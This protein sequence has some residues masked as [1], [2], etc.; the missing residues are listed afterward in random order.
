[1]EVKHNYGPFLIIVPMSTLHN[2][3]EFECDRWLPG[4]SKVVYD[5]DKDRRKYLRENFIK[6]GHFNIIMTTFEFAMRDKNVLRKIPWKYIIIDEAHRL[7]NPSCFTADTQIAMANGF[8]RPICS[9]AAGTRVLS[10]DAKL[11]GHKPVATSHLLYQGLKSCVELLFNDGRTVTCTLDHRFMQPDSSWIE[12]QHMQLHKSEIVAGVEYPTLL[13]EPASDGAWTLRLSEFL[14][15]DL[16]MQ[17][18]SEHALAFAGILGYL[19]AGSH[20]VDAPCGAVLLDHSLDVDWMLRDI[21]LLTDESA[22]TSSPLRVQLP[23]ALHRALLAVGLSASGLSSFPSFLLRPDCPLAVLQAFLGGLFGRAGQSPKISGQSFSGV[24]LSLPHFGSNLQKTQLTEQLQA[25]F[26]RVG[27]EDCAFNLSSD[28]TL[29]FAST[30]GFRYCCHKAMRLTAAVLFHRM[31]ERSSRLGAFDGVNGLDLSLDSAL[32]AFDVAKFFT[33]HHNA[34]PA[35]AKALPTCRVQ[36]IARRA[37]EGMLPTFDLTVPRTHNFLA[38]AL[39][40]HNCKLAQ[41]LAT[42]PKEARRVALTG[43]PLQNDLVE[44][45][46]LLNF[47]HPHIF[48]SSDSFEK[49]F[50][51]PFDRMPVGTQDKEREMTMNEEEKLLVIN[52]LHSILRPFMLR[53]EKKQ[54]ESD[55]ADKIEK[56]LRCEL[57][58]MQKAMYEAVLEGKVTMHN[59]IMQLRKIA[60]HPILFHPYL[61]A[62]ARSEPYTPDESLIKMCGKFG[63]LD[64][65]LHKLK[66]TGHRVLIFNQMTKVM[67]ILED[68][69]KLRSFTY[70]RL[71]G[72]TNAEDR[73]QS[74]LK[75]NAKD[76]PYFLFMLST[77]AGGLGLNLQSADTVILFDSDWSVRAMKRRWA[78]FCCWLACSCFARCVCSIF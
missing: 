45:W 63:L 51:T 52:R 65:I 37:V 25:M 8:S 61:R 16:D 55:L 40:A 34:V 31:Q 76:S 5:G 50:S 15:Y 64:Q 6:P 32:D 46:S 66:R 39:T 21:C 11:D 7:K 48:N 33:M 30:I 62:Q 43:T 53:R 28:A 72:G 60:N 14:T 75:Y 69:C 41:E 58:P 44:L 42:Y 70:L 3:W 13:E 17:A 29:R 9:V 59:K 18:R 56:V 27:I 36:L 77:R 54:V 71:D 19:V 26:K 23:V 20:C 49:W 67:D 24:Q 12:A 1:M 68:Y 38:N 74:L 57:T 35:G 47:L 22:A 78:N 73:T 2:N 4:L 10:Y